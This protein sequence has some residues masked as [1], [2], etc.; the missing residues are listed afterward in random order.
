MHYSS[1]DPFAKVVGLIKDMIAKLEEEAAAD[2]AEKAYCDKE[3]AETQTKRADKNS[4]IE[5][6]TTTIDQKSAESEKLKGEVKV[7]QA[8][9]AK[10]AASQAE[11]DKI[12]EEEHAAYL[13]N[14][15]A[16]ELGLGGVR[17]AL[18]ILRDYYAGASG[19]HVEASG[20]GAGIVGLLEVVESDFSKSLA[21]MIA[22]E[23]TAQADYD[24]QTKENEIEK[25]TKDQDVK[26]KT[27]FYTDLDKAIAELKGD[28]TGVENELAAVMEYLTSLN[29][30]CQG[31]LGTSVF[32]NAKAESYAE[33]KARREAEIAGL[34]EGL[35]I[36][37]GEQSTVLL[38]KRSR[39]LLLKLK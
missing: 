11:M 4:E 13:K 34:K 9:L 7:L 37:D 22:T 30:R 36:L 25:T 10:L 1:G 35:A 38:Q 39:Q 28:R 32:G 5:K 29:D 20:A 33:R 18:Q 8:E 19:G 21:E 14:R 27:K 15:A 12:R 2:A 6:L 16:M 3:I 24:A 31:T 17:K 26:Y 23:E